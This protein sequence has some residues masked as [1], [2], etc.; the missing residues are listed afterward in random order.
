[1]QQRADQC[2]AAQPPSGVAADRRAVVEVGAAHFGAQREHVVVDHHQHL[3]EVVA[4]VGRAAG[5]Q[6]GPG[7]RR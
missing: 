1:V 2:V 6:R 5:G 3:H 7:Q 4:I